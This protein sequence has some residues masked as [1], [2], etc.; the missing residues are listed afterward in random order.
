MDTGDIGEYH[1]YALTF[2]A[3]QRD[4]RR[5]CGGVVKSAGAQQ[6]DQCVESP[7][8]RGEEV[9]GEGEEM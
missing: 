1:C 9:G 3:D 2:N 6:L 5:G 8:M 4:R 7:G